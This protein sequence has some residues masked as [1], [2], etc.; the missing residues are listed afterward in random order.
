MIVAIKKIILF[1]SLKKFL[2]LNLKLITRDE[3]KNITEKNGKDAKDKRPKLKHKD[4]KFNNLFL[5]II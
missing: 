2:N 4:P 3:I 5:F 1:L